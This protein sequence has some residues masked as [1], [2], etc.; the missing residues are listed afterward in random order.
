MFKY[1]VLMTSVSGTLGPKNIE[2][3]KNAISGKVW[4]L[5]VETW[6]WATFKGLGLSVER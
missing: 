2:F 4:V 1:K 6:C 5:G 3:M